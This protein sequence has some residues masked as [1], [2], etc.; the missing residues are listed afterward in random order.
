MG[1][2]PMDDQQRPDET[3]EQAHEEAPPKTAEQ[4]QRDS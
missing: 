3:E 4:W 1:R 2:P